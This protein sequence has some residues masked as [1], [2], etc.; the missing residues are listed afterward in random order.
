MLGFQP[1]ETFQLLIET[2]S[3]DR[4]NTLLVAA[5]D[6]YAR[7]SAPTQPLCIGTATRFHRRP[8]R[9]V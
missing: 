1:Y 9:S 2:G 3:T 5:C 8:G 7:R 6:A 4:I